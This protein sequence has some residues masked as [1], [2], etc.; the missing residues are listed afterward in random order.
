MVTQIADRKYLV[1]GL[2]EAL[3][4]LY[5]AYAREG[6]GQHPGFFLQQAILRHADDGTLERILQDVK[7]EIAEA[8]AGL[9]IQPA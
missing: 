4:R 5:K 1:D 2:N 8:E 3:P 7:Q 9:Q 6:K